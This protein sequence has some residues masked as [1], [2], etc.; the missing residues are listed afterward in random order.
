MEFAREGNYQGFWKVGKGVGDISAFYR[1]SPSPRIR[2]QLNLLINQPNTKNMIRDERVLPIIRRHA[3][4]CLY[5]AEGTNT[6][7]FRKV[8]NSGRWRLWGNHSSSGY[9]NLRSGRRRRDIATF[10]KRTSAHPKLLL[11]LLGYPR[12]LGNE[13]LSPPSTGTHWLASCL[14]CGA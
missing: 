13:R 1:N 5:V 10:E 2:Q 11:G 12:E 7:A 3:I 6:K 4:L 14:G 8:G 9:G